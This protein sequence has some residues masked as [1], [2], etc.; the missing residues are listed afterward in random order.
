MYTL[1]C[2]H[3]TFPSSSFHFLHTHLLCPPQDVATAINQGL[4][5]STE[6][7]ATRHEKLYKT[8]TTHTSHTWAAILV[9]MLLEQM[10]LQGM[11]RQTPYIPRK[12][13]EGLYHTAGKRLFLFDYDVRPFLPPFLTQLKLNE[14]TKNTGN[15]RTHHENAIYGRSL[16]SD[17]RNARNALCGPEEYRIHHLRVEHYLQN[18]SVATWILYL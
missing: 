9:K 16:R 5:M 7:K 2:V 3:F 11:A 13:L 8:V 17:A 12:N 1:F 10:G 6:E 15:A 4:L 14:T 18:E